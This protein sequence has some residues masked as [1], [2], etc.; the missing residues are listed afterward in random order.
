MISATSDFK[1]F[2]RY[3][4]KAKNASGENGASYH[5]LVFHCLDVA[6]VGHCLLDPEMP[7]CRKLA[8]ELG[9]ST[10]WLRAWFTFCLLLHDLGKFFR[11]FQNL[12]P[13]LSERLVPSDTRCDYGKRHDTLGYLLWKQKLAAK[14]IDLLQG[15]SP[16]KLS[17]WLE[18]VCG[19][20]GQPPEQSSLATRN[21]GAYLLDEDIAAAELFIREVANHWLPDLTP[22]TSINSECFKRVSWELAGLAVLADWIG[23]D[24]R[25]FKYCDDARGLEDYWQETA[26]PRAKEV[27]AIVQFEQRQVMPFNNI[28]Q[29]FPFI[30]V[31][32]PLQA[33][34]EVMVLGTQ[35]Q[36]FILEDVTGAGKTEAAMTLVHRLMAA[37]LANGVYVGLPTMATANAM[38]ERMEHSYRAL[39]AHNQS[40]SLVLSHSARDLSANFRKSVMVSEQASDKSYGQQELSA[41]AYCNQWLADNRK[42][43][44]LADVGVG[45]ID[46]A[47]LAV[48]P[49]RF[50]SLRLFGLA[51]KVLLVDEV[52]SYD[53]YMRQL[54][55]ALL[56]AHAAQKG[57]AILLSATLPSGFRQELLTAYAQGAGEPLG[58]CLPAKAY[59][60]LTHLEGN[61]LQETV[62]G[63]RPSVRRTVNVQRIADEASVYTLIKRSVEQGLCVCWIR[64]TVK[65]A[66]ATWSY[67]SEQSWITK[68]HLTLFHSR[69]AMVDRQNI[70]Q[71]VMAT[72]GKKS[73]G[74]VRTQQVLIAT[75]VVEQSLD[76]DFDVLITDLA[77]VDLLIQRA[78]RLQRHIRSVNGD[79]IEEGILDERTK[80]CLHVLAPD[81]DQVMDKEWLHKLLPGTQAVYPHLGQLWLSLKAVLQN[82]GFTMPDD[83]RQLIESVYAEQAHA[84]IPE[85]LLDLSYTAEGKQRG[86]AS[87]GAF[88]CLKLELGY[89][90]GTA[91]QNSHWDDDMHIPTRL[92]QDSVTIVLARLVQSELQPYTE[93]PDPRAAWALSQL[94]VPQAEWR[95]AE[96]DV[97]KSLVSKIKEL[98]ENTSGLRWMEVLPLVEG[99]QGYYDSVKGWDSLKKSL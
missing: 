90:R 86:D 87:M 46:Q 20:H 22:I 61:K 10:Q 55:I 34:A 58:T 36:L 16:S 84:N 69:Y 64:N 38:Y 80:P 5:L 97:P 45:T 85:P 91:G 66:R 70:E 28:Q 56:K 59:P 18:I 89:T 73:T 40:A 75:Q 81:P 60:L 57:S 30:K 47:L 19:H 88:N 12:A 21:L 2:Y 62:V 33:Q 13:D 51:S 50:Q 99:T 67:L 15:V 7:L 96:A 65:D 8:R 41:S 1:P 6:A 72:F 63:T 95:K 25:I 68:E 3:W 26:L 74:A 9:V 78:G 98:K 48:L 32:T 79:L 42:K 49:A 24:Q 71:T 23:S 77:P 29:Q 94:S 82:N 35:P 76:L 93:H 37:G 39:Y 31:A 17:P 83:A 14:L 52:H 92:G 53:P 4:G 11:S 44:L 27:L 43:A 54:L